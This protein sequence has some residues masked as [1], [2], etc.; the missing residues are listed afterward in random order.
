MTS[1]TVPNACFI[2]SC[3]MEGNMGRRQTE[4]KTSEKGKST[5]EIRIYLQNKNITE[6]RRRII[7]GKAVDD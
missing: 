7:A 1:G 6:R 2:P 4:K 3:I 5:R